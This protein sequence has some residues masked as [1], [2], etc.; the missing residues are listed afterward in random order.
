[1]ANHPVR[2]RKRLRHFAHSAF[3]CLLVMT[4]ALPAL[5]E[6]RCTW[7][8]A[9]TAAAVLG[10]EVRLT[11]T[12]GSCEFVHQE[13]SLRIEV[14][15]TNAPHAKCGSPAE[16][17]RAIGNEAQ[18]CAYL[19]KPGWIAEQVVGRVRDQAFLVRISTKDQSAAPKIL[20]EK[21][22]KVAEQVAGILF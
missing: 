18:A 3:P 4:S 5:A 22:R 1:M 8:N 17:L 14:A 2:R 19:G 7:L 16:Q 10:G 15:T 20:R 6:D 11:I 9:A 13:T 12:P 21:A